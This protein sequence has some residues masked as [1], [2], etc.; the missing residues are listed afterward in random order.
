MSL[1]TSARVATNPLRQDQDAR[2]DEGYEK[3][4]CVKAAHCQSTFGGRFVKQIPYRGP[5]RARKDE[6]SP[7]QQRVRP[8][9]KEIC[10]QEQR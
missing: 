7:E 3:Y 8:I 4:R 2:D 1:L 10:R 5:E 9:R 6:S